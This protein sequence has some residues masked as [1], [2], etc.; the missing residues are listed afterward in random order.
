MKFQNLSILKIVINNIGFNKIWV[1]L[2]IFF[3][4]KIKILLKIKFKKNIMDLDTSTGVSNDIK[5]TILGV[6]AVG[7]S[8]VT[9]RFI[10]N[11]FTDDY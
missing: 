9:I 11:L 8:S 6:S 3:L 1:F 4:I 7:K 10:M 2:I 5:I